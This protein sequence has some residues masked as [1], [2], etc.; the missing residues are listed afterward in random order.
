MRRRRKEAEEGGGGGG[1]RR[2]KSGSTIEAELAVE[3]GDEVA[4][5]LL[6]FAFVETVVAIIR[7]SHVGIEVLGEQG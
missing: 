3:G 6:L 7:G 1:G 5:L 2:E 4:V